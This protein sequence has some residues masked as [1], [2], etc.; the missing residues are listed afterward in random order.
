MRR[1]ALV[2]LLVPAGAGCGGDKGEEPERGG[3]PPSPLRDPDRVGRAGTEHSRACD[4]LPARDVSRLAGH[5]GTRLRARRNDSLDLSICTW[6]G[7]RVSSV[8]VSVDSATHAELRFYNLQAEQQE[9]H[10]ADPGQR[11]R[12]VRGV[13][14][15]SAYGGAGAWWTRDRHQLIAFAQRRILRVRVTVSG[16]GDAERRRAAISLARLTFARLRAS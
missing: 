13:G 3:L 9:Y 1:G 14:R 2:L 11:I 4:L 6:S 15:D 12:Q 5:P 16:A 8:Q 7:K 10:A